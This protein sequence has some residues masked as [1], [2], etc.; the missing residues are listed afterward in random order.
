MPTPY[1]ILTACDEII[2]S[3][4]Q[5][6]VMHLDA[7]DERLDGRLVTVEGKP[8]VNFGSCSYLGLEMHPELKN[9]VI[10]AVEKY[11]TQF[12]SSRAYISSP[13]Y[14]RAE[15][16]LSTN[17]DRPVLVAPT[18]TLGHMAFFPSVLSEQDALLLDIQ[19]H[20]SVQAAAKLARAQGTIV[21]IVPHNNMQV[22]RRKIIAMQ[23]MY[24]RIWY[25][26][27]GLYSMYA[28]YAPF[29]EL[30]ALVEEFPSL[31]L[32][33]DDSHAISW[34]GKYGRGSALESLS[35]EALGRT[36]VVGGL[37]KSFAA[38]GGALAFPD[39]EMLRRVRTV[40]G[41]MMFSGP[42]QPPMLGAL[43]ASADLHRTDEVS[44]RQADLV[45]LIELFNAEASRLQLPLVSD[46]TA[47]IRC[48]GA[49]VPDVA[50]GVTSRL[51]EAGF[52]VDTAV[53]PAVPAKRAGIRAT[54]TCHHTEDDV[55]E[56][57][58]AIARALPESLAAEGS[59]TEQLVQSF[60]MQLNGRPVQLATASMP[61]P[62]ANLA[63]ERRN[64]VKH[65][66]RAEWDQM[67]ADR[68]IF[69]STGMEVLEKVFRNT[70][71]ISGEGS[72]FNYFIVRDETGRPV[73]ATLFTTE[74]WKE[75]MLSS[76][77]VSE[78]VERRRNEDPEY[79]TSVMVA[80][81]TL[82]SEG[83][84]L[85]L[86]RSS[87]DWKAALRLI[88]S[89]ARRE[90]DAA[91]A[92]AVILRDL[93][94]GD[95]ELREFLSGEGFLR[96]PMPATWVGESDYADSAAYR[97]SLSKRARR[98][99]KLEVAPWEDRYDI[100][101]LAGGLD[102][103]SYVDRETLAHL[104]SLYL[105][106]HKRHLELNTFELP[107]NF[108]ET[109]LG[110]ANWELVLLRPKGKPSLPVAFGLT[111]IGRGSV[112]GVYLGLDDNNSK[113]YRA[114]HI[115]LRELVRAA[116]RHQ[117]TKIHFGL[118]GGFVKSRFGAKPVHSWLYVQPTETYNSQVLLHLSE[119]L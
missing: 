115:L 33:V 62:S 116:S 28:D 101:V 59:S 37:S 5:R 4:V 38:G 82:V 58:S 55:K 24:T 9:A 42:V 86:D 6:K 49:G 14:R 17:F 23:S 71:D 70:E 103:A 89:A 15:E 85:F 46:S 83:N 76:A 3:G 95:E 81:G 1:E 79:L 64:S 93:P 7:Q 50:Y 111:H 48:I 99:Q 60:R 88:I 16:S 44:R 18:A 19:V 30:N 54:L 29:E 106:V 51:R 90:E 35:P 26:C 34:S 91:G 67:F 105:N 52:F 32:Y 75:D 25:A 56:L 112:Q 92:S 21:E 104:H 102:G 107:S 31:C 11:G 118:T 84:H 68:G 87:P 74:R 110:S 45:R 39:S 40:G 73:A 69:T 80:M 61:Q 114:Y 72:R 98:Y 10:S 47:P 27:D 8:L 77:E 100:Q 43:C 78:E 63:M 117:A 66:N 22:L 113:S 108:I 97:S 36:V 41:P 94:D 109:A 20:S 96:F 2:S 53:Y 65:L 57:V 13:G 119:R 12:S